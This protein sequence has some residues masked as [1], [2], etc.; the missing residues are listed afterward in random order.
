MVKLL[1]IKLLFPTVHTQH[2]QSIIFSKKK[3]N[4]TLN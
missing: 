1:L 3:T 2:H 4:E